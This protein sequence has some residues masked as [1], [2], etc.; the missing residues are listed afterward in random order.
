MSFLDSDIPFWP[1]LLDSDVPMGDVAAAE[2]FTAGPVDHVAVG[3]ERLLEQFKGE[4]HPLIQALAAAPL[5]LSNRLE[6]VTYTL[7]T[8]TGLDDAV[9]AWLDEWGE[10]LGLE[11]DGW[12]DDRYRELLYAQLYAL[13]SSG[14]VPDVYRVFEQLDGDWEG[15]IEDLEFDPGS[16]RVTWTDPVLSEQLA[17]LYRRFLQ[18]SRAAAVKVWFYSWPAPGSSLFTFESDAGGPVADSAR[19]MGAGTFAREKIA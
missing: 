12:S 13:R 8:E 15:G 5:V 9:G 3:V 14:T 2:I 1:A 11:R 19:G 7:L 6:G 4:A 16:F 17:E 18:R 10:I